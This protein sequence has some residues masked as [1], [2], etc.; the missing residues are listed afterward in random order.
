[1]TCAYD[2]AYLEKARSALGR[3][4][5]VGV[6]EFGY[7]LGEFFDLFVGSGLAER[8]GKGDPALTVGKSGAELAYAVLQASGVPIE[9]M[10]VRYEAS[11]SPEYW[12][13]W[14]L[15]Y[16]QWKVGLPFAEIA[17]AVSL[18]SVREMYPAFHEMDIRQFADRMDELYREARPSTSLQRRRMDAGLSQRQLAALSG[19]PVRSIQQYEQRQKALGRAAF[20][21]VEALAQALCCGP[22]DLVDPEV[23]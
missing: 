9:R 18:D 17:A 1:M 14:A 23:G 5:D 21:T 3:M 13:G 12:V 6:N 7:E 22:V 10:P 11:R 8:F 19:V 20:S 16:Y 2:K 15:A 4:L